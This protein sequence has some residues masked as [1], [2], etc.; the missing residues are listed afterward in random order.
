MAS[1]S[2]QRDYPYSNPCADGL[3][4]KV[5]S[6]Q[7]HSAGEDC[8]RFARQEGI[9]KVLAEHGLDAIAAPT[10][11]PAWLTDPINADHYTGGFSSPAAVA[12]YPHI[13]LPAGYIS[14]LPVGLSFTAGPYSEA[15]LLKLAYAFEQAV[16]VRR[17]PQFLP[18][19][20]LE[21]IGLAQ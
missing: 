5:Y 20:S 17:P 7:T 18:T 21:A 2:P 12:G 1:P 11:G 4:E 6:T 3:L 15:G 10:R 19:A 16:Q 14:G 9:D 13:T 8:L